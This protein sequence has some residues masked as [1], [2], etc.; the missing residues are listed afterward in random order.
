MIETRHQ[1]WAHIV[2]RLYLHRLFQRNFHSIYL[3]GDM[4]VHQTDQPVLLLPNH[5][6]W[7][8][9]FFIYLLNEKVLKRPLYLMMLER[10]LKKY[11]FFSRVGAFSIDPQHPKSVL[12][13][14]S[15]CRT[16]L[17]LPVSPAP[18]VCLFPQGELRPYHIRPLG[19]ENGFGWIISKVTKQLTILTLGIRIEFL[20]H[21]LPEVFFQFGRIETSDFLKSNATDLLENSL[22]GLL[23]SIQLQILSGNKRRCIFTGSSSIN[24]KWD[25]LARISFHQRG[26]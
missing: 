4:P 11:S 18:V 12:T 23:D 22:N 5:S 3:L 2:F 15:Y 14:L 16:I 7:W 13:S 8:D 24:E 19:I 9:G 17:E 20:D 10:R 21:Q 25:S 26:K 1:K 6:N